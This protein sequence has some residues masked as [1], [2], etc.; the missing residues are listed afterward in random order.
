MPDI[1]SLKYT[2]KKCSDLLEEEIRKSAA[3][4][5]DNYGFYSSSAPEKAGEQIRLGARYYQ[6]LALQSN[7]YV[8]FAFCGDELVGQAYYVLLKNASGYISWVIQLVVSLKF[9]NMKIA[10]RLL[11]SV[12]GFSN[13]SAWGLATSN[14]LTIKTLEAS[15]LRT[16]NFAVMKK[17]RDIITELG[18][19]ISFIKDREIVI[20][21]GNAYVDTEFYVDHTDIPAL[22]D[23]FS[24]TGPWKF[25]DLPEGYEWVAFVFKEQKLDTLSRE[26]ITEIFEYSEQ[27]VN[28]AYSRMDMPSHNWAKYAPAEVGVIEDYIPSKLSRIIDFGCGRGRHT[29][30]LYQRGYHNISAIDFS[31]R[32]IKD[33]KAQNPNFSGI[34]QLQDCRLFSE[35]Q[36]VD[37]AL[38]LY[39]VIGSFADITENDK[40]I[41]SIVQSLKP[42]GILI[43]SV[44]NMELT[45]SII[46]KKCNVYENPQALFDLKAS[47]TMQAT[48]D[49]FNP[50]F[51]LLD[52]DSGCIIRKEKFTNDGG[53]FA[54]Y[55]VRDRRYR[56]SDIMTIADK[57]N[58]ELIELRYVQAGRW[59]RS[60]AN[61]D[62]KAKEILAILR[63]K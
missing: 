20:E 3:L 33:C 11:R 40:I 49:I 61:T 7:T 55:I 16:P 32:N 46:T 6:N 59:D 29:S 30:E 63:M 48:G 18:E 10:T 9:R 56:S 38:A 41:A 42:K 60:L 22:I 14:P 45:D 27:C 13:D 5:S 26:T 15:T 8:S 36:T 39:D 44:M 25:G 62:P 23:I 12:W 52:T 54:E 37:V 51:L 57:Y 47:N 35:K 17:N 1:S 19:Q 50:E 2:T 21:D 34:F 4:F 31:E 43:L 58:L 53:L 28:D 24:K